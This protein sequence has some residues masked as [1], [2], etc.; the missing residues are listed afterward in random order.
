MGGREGEKLQCVVA[1]QVSPTGD[2]AHNT[3]MR[4]DWELNWWPFGLQASTQFTEPH[5]PGL[6]VVLWKKYFKIHPCCFLKKP[7][8]N[9]Y[10]QT[11]ASEEFS[12][13]ANPALAGVAQLVGASSCNRKVVASIP[14]QSTYQG[15]GFGPHPG[16]IRSLGTHGRQPVN[17]SITSMFLSLPSSVSKK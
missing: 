17:A 3:G 12:L 7:P 10:S 8:T 4:P 15:C 2:L 13:K 14:G 9:P 16:C 1:S 5:Q 6:K 11:L